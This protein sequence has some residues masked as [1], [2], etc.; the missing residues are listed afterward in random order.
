MIK[1][2]AP[3]VSASTFP[4]IVTERVAPTSSPTANVTVLLDGVKSS[5]ELVSL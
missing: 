3:S 4:V 5:V 1:A 2:S